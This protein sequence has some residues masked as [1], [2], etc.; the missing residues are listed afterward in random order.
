MSRTTD[1]EVARQKAEGCRRCELWRD[2]T[3]TVFGEGTVR[4]RAMLVGEQPGDAE[5]VQGRPFVGPAGVLLRHVLEEVGLREGELYLT[6]AVKH[7]KWRPKGTR[8]IHDTPNRSEIRA[9]D[10]WLRLELASVQPELLVLLGGTAAQAFLG[11]DA[12]VT[13]LRGSVLEVPEVEMPVVVTLHP[14]AILR[15]GERRHE[16]RAELVDDLTLVRERLAAPSRRTAGRDPDAFSEQG[17]RV[18]AG[19]RQP[20]AKEATMPPRGV[21]KGTKRARQ[22]EH[23]KDSL[24]DEGRSEGTAEEIAARTVNKERAR[25][26]EAQTSSRLSREDISSG[27]RGGLRS[28]RK[29]PRGRTRDQLY[30]EAKDKNVKGRSKMT[31]AQLARA[32][33]R[34]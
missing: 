33:G 25:H 28:H 7:F 20:D 5:D 1:L 30:E 8:R 34:G 9:C 6:N 13:R 26:G 16:R 23:I 27:R 3:Q 10:L 24:L 14:S 32:V 29:A 11:R 21:K 18:S 4:A 22:Y 15:A 31:K 12:R 2:A 17:A 19:Q